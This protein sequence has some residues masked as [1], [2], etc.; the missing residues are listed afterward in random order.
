VGYHL[1]HEINDTYD[2]ETKENNF[3]DSIIIPKTI[4]NVILEFLHYVTERK[5]GVILRCKL[6]MR[7]E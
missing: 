3:Y 6:A 7:N 2:L 4:S 5:M 1:S